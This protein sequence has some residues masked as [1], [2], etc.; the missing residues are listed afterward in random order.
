MD[1]LLIFEDVGLTVKLERCCWSAYKAGTTDVVL[2]KRFQF[3]LKFAW[4]ITAH[5]VQG[6]TLKAAVVH[7]GNEF[8]PGQLYVACSRVSS[9]EGLKTVGF[10]KNKLIK[11]D[12]HVTDFF[13]NLNSSKQTLSDDLA[14]CRNID[15]TTEP[16][17]HLH[18]LK[19]KLFLIQCLSLNC[20]RLRKSAMNISLDTVKTL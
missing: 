20:W 19:R 16:I 2:G 9:K 18:N 13:A 12:S 1:Q 7:S 17:D 14:C 3:P 4:G 11:Q 8:V 6:Q 15:I 5:K 10:N